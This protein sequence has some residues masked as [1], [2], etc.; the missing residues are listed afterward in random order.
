MCTW[1]VRPCVCLSAFDP[2][3][4]CAVQSVE[5]KKWRKD[6]PFGFYAKPEKNADGSTNLLVWRC[7]IPGKAKV[8]SHSL[9]LK[10]AFCFLARL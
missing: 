1:F 3:H 10:L 8:T 7:G 4:P 9:K 6:R 5:R 2:S